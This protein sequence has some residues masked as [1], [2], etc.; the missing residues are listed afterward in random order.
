MHSLFLIHR[1]LSSTH[2]ILELN[3]EHLTRST[4]RSPTTQPK[5]IYGSVLI[6]EN[7]AD[8]VRG[9]RL[10]ISSLYSSI[11]NLGI[12]TR[13]N[14]QEDVLSWDLDKPR[15][16]KIGKL[17]HRIAL[18]FDR[19]LGSRVTETRVQFQSDWTI[20]ILNPHL[21]A[22]SHREILQWDLLSDT[23]TKTT[24]GTPFTNMD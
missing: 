3:L 10:V 17:N 9:F 1:N 20:R 23:C 13:F 24:P 14:I 12:E 15:S 22:S 8:D 21:W 4:K 18:K 6:A 2:V 5:Y 7:L 19:R 16:C 11:V